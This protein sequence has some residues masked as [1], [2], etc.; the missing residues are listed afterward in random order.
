MYTHFNNLC[1][2]TIYLILIELLEVSTNLSNIRYIS[3]NKNSLI[4]TIYFKTI[5][6][7]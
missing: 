3:K 7:N 4:A 6:K 2:I 5:I 1:N